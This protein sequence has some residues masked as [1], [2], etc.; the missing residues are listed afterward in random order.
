MGCNRSGLFN[1]ELNM[2][3]IEVVYLMLILSWVLIDSVYN[4]PNAYYK[5]HSIINNLKKVVKKF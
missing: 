2:V 1:A 4:S 3:P 5:Y